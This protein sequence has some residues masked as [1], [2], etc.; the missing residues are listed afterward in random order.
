MSAVT[1]HPHTDFEKASPSSSVD[2]DKLDPEKG[3]PY[4]D[5]A[6]VNDFEDPNYDQAAGALEDES[7]YPEVRSAVANTDDP[8]MPASTFR[9]WV[10][11][12]IWAIIIPGVNQF[13]F[14]R[15]PSVNIT[16]IVPQLLTFPVCK[17]W[18]YAMPN[19]RFMGLSINPGPF[20]VKEHVIITIMA[21]VGAQSA[22]AVRPFISLHVD[23]LADVHPPQQT[24][25]IAVQRVYYNQTYNFG[26]QW[27][28]V[29]ST[30]LIGFSIG[31]ICKRFLVSPPSMIWPANLVTCA[32]FNTLHHSHTAGS[33][34][35]GGISR[36]RFFVYVFVG[37]VCYIRFFST[38]S[39]PR[40][41]V[42]FFPLRASWTSRHFCCI[43]FF[44]D[45]EVDKCLFRD[46]AD[47]L[48]TYLFTALSTFSWVTWIAPNNIKVNQMFG[49]Q[50]GL[51]MGLVTFDWANIAYNNS[52]LPVP[53][54]AAANVGISL[55]FFFWFLTPILYYKNV[56]NSQYMP[57]VSRGSFDNTG[58]AYNVSRILTADA[59]IDVAA[60]KAYSPLF[61]S[62][63]FAVSYGLS[64]ASIPAT[65]THIFLYYRK[66][67]WT[68]ARRS[69]SEQPDIHARLMS[70]YPQVPDWWYAIV[71]LSMFVFGIVAIEVWNT[72]FPVWAFVLSLVVAFFYTVPIGIIQAI[73]NQ[74]VGLNVITEL[75]IGYALPGR[76]VA[77]MM[78]KTWGY[79]TMAQALQFTQDFKLGH[80][81]KVPPRPM[82]WCQVVATVIAGTVQLGVQ[83]WLFSHVRDMCSVDQPDG[84]ICPSTEV[85]GTASIIVRIR[86][87]FSVC[88][89]G[90]CADLVWVFVRQWGVIG[91]ARQFSKGQMYYAL[92]FFFLIGAVAPIIQ[93]LIH[94]KWKYPILKYLKC[95][96]LSSPSP[97]F[98]SP[99]RCSSKNLTLPPRDSFPIIFSGTGNL[100]PATPIN[101][102]PWVI[103]GRA[104]GRVGLG[105]R[106]RHAYYLLLDGIDPL[107]A[108]KPAI[109]AERGDREEHD[110]D[111]VG[112]HGVRDD[113]GRAGD[114]FADACGGGDVWAVDVVRVWYAS[115][116][117]TRRA[118]L[119][120]VLL[121]ALLPVARAD[122]FM[123]NNGF[124]HCRMS[125][126]ARIAI[127]VCLVTM[128]SR[129]M[130]NLHEVASSMH[131]LHDTSLSSGATIAFTIR[132]D[133]PVRQTG[134][135]GL[136]S[137]S[138]R[139]PQPTRVPSS[140]GTTG[141][142]TLSSSTASSLFTNK[143]GSPSGSGSN[144]GAS[145]G[146]KTGGTLRSELQEIEL[147]D[148]D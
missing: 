6:P 59:T 34:A 106:R 77:M 87:P 58:A 101:Y 76:P 104:L 117:P 89:C 71:F 105:V 60:Y 19:W 51:A 62:T 130:L 80:Y 83:S 78:F 29:M 147:A 112:Q 141:R 14:F 124:E 91:P 138:S 82:F 2:A 99:C 95:V 79:I 118:L 108:A 107:D 121:S 98:L 27:L 115:Y 52:P 21:G 66:Q 68:Q 94:K 54:W 35:R 134:L 61:I 53:W 145:A 40:L 23:E 116:H 70:V 102:V 88:V 36:E 109:P 55:V 31:G 131:T 139:T 97:S 11:G 25:I 47:F 113:G 74:Q 64:F 85:F 28:V 7:P 114:A 3:T 142:S 12:V 140:Q 90:V 86:I 26:Y 69:L 119:S 17:L 57:I 30:Q 143:A 46:F 92:V 15:Y 43:V 136:S 148:M 50:H 41:R 120:L 42:S 24:D 37:Y 67:I 38:A 93:W 100:P 122:C 125:T 8:S 20:T 72:Q 75:I 146:R 73:T 4:D 48:P 110:P 126:G 39:R 56:W 123:D 135:D 22:Y 32:L 16:Q 13:F 133:P 49:Y 132:I 144:G 111:V 96:L 137:L 65:L 127:A 33:G 103:V 84:F 1:E 63:A 44:S 5:A 45:A 9:A 128:M 18:A 81:M 129:L 10:I